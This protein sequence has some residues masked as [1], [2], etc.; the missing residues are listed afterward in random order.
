MA[1]AGLALIGP[2]RRH[3]GIL[4][5][6]RPYGPW[7]SAPVDP[8]FVQAAVL[9]RGVCTVRALTSRFA[10]SRCVFD[11]AYDPLWCKPQRGDRKTVG[12]RQKFR[13]FLIVSSLLT[14][15]LRRKGLR[16]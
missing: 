4:F 10:R 12:I 13:K 8:C 7:C 16:P 14:S 1:G 2:I 5:A 15:A 3:C 11:P 6:A 9:G